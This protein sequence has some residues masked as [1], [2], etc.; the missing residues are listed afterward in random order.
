MNLSNG[1][2]RCNGRWPRTPTAQHQ[3]RMRA[4]SQVLPPQSPASSVIKV[5]RT[6]LTAGIPERLTYTLAWEDH[7]KIDLKWQ[8]PIRMKDGSRKNLIYVCT[9]LDHVPGKS[10]VYVFARRF[11]KNVVPL[12]VGQALRLRDS[13]RTTAEQCASYDGNKAGADREAHS[14]GWASDDAPGAAKR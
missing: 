13:G 7:V 9:N 6:R 8:K 11:G 3:M 4:R 5:E 1:P 12:Y 10:G 2:G 14:D